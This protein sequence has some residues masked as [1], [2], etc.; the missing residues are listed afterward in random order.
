MC[1]K[2]K[3]IKIIANIV[4]IAIL[5]SVVFFMWF[6]HVLIYDDFY[7]LSIHIV[8]YNN[9]DVFRIFWMGWIAINAIISTASKKHSKVFYVIHLVLAAIS[10]LYF[11]W[12]LTL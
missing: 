2:K 1:T 9:L 10:C 7:P 11:L 12:I 4:H 6:T 8:D 5:L 3:I